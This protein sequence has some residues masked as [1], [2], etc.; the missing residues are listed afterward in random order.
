[1]WLGV[2]LLQKMSE[3]IHMHGDKPQCCVISEEICEG[4]DDHWVRARNQRQEI[5]LCPSAGSMRQ[6]TLASVNAGKNIGIIG[7]VL[8]GHLWM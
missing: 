2:G 1:M 8:I 5:P 3:M 4:K 6:I 7:A